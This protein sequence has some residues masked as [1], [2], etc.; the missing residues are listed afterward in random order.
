MHREFRTA[1]SSAQDCHE[2]RLPFNTGQKTFR[3]L[4]FCNYLLSSSCHCSWRSLPLPLDSNCL[5]IR[6]KVTGNDACELKFYFID[7]PNCLLS[8]SYSSITI[9]HTYYR[10]AATK[11]IT[12]SQSEELHTATSMWSL[13][14]VC[15]GCTVLWST[16]DGQMWNLQ[17]HHFTSGMMSPCC[18]S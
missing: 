14:H 8:A 7:Q 2:I 13:Q 5:Y 16:M 11:H 18:P 3:V 17:D 12:Q 4:T 1:P 10:L 15:T 9:R 6:E